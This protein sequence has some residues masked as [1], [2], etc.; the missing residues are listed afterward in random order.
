MALVHAYSAKTH[1]ERPAE[2]ANIYKS[3]VNLYNKGVLKL[4]A[5]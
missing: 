5:N 4:E 1:I 2:E 3:S